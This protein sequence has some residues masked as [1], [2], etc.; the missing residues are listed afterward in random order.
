MVEGLDVPR[1]LDLGDRARALEQL[2]VHPAAHSQMVSTVMDILP[3]REAGLLVGSRRWPLPAARTQNIHESDSTHT[4]AWQLNRLTA[5]TS[6]KQAT[7]TALVGRLV[8]ATLHSLATPLTVRPA[9][10]SRLWVSPM[11]ARS[12][13]TTPTAAPGGS[14]P[15][16]VGERGGGADR[17]SGPG[18]REWLFQR[19]GAAPDGVGCLVLG[20]CDPSVQVGRDDLQ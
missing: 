6:C 4:V 13:S 8:D 20:G 16:P 19:P 9:S 11:A 7:G 14:R 18:R 3:E 15:S 2:K 17:A 12:R 1:D 5:D 10:A